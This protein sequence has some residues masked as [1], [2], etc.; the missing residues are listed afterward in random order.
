MKRITALFIA[1]LIFLPGIT[2]IAEDEFEEFD[3]FD[4]YGSIISDTEFDDEIEF[5]EDF[6]DVS[7]E[8]FQDRKNSLDSLS[9]YHES[10]VFDAGDFKYKQLEDGESCQIVRYIGIDEDVSVPDQLKGLTVKALYMTFSDNSL[11]ETVELPET[12]EKIDNMAFW[13]CVGLKHLEIPE[14]V[15]EIGRCSFGGCTSLE[16]I[17]LPESLENVDEMVFLMCV[18]LKE[19]T[20]GKNLKSI[21]S[22]AFTGCTAL[23]K[24]VV[25]K[26]TEIAEDAFIQCP[27]LEEIEYYDVE[28]EEDC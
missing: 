5:D 22:Q 7:E 15:T 2:S 9:G 8:E 26:G 4:N 1:L 21:G 3:D 17:V 27:L 6:S 20:F 16:S 28:V 18:E 25:P 23:E 12:I 19:L 24:V 14:G 11:L 13:K 10:D